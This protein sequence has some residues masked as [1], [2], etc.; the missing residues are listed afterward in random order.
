MNPRKLLR[1]NFIVAV[2]VLAAC[3]ASLQ[4]IVHFQQWVLRKEPIELRRGLILF[5]DQFG[6][7]RIHEIDGKPAKD[8]RLSKE[9]EEVLGTDTYISWVFRDTRK[10]LTEPGSLLRLHVAYYTGTIDTVPHVPERC[11]TASGMTS[12]DRKIET[13]NL[14]SPRIIREADG[15]AIATSAAG[16]RVNL[17]TVEVPVRV[18]RFENT[19]RSEQPPM[20]VTYL[21]AANGKYVPTPEDVRLEAFNLKDRYSYYCKI[22]VTPVGLTEEEPAVDAVEQFLT[23][24]LPEVM[25]CLPDWEQV[26]AGEYP[27]D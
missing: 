21:F 7:Y 5:A 24:A 11:V 14:G 26:R 2:V 16:Q 15:T 3:A 25:V 9:L 27:V 19:Q 22:E 10:P 1:P 6:P 8:R 13:V 20:Y 4:A 23:W 18:I 12:T 17:P